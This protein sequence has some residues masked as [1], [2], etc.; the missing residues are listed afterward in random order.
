MK[1]LS[2]IGKGNNERGTPNVD[3]LIISVLGP[4]GCGKGT[5]CELLE[6]RYHCAHICAGD[7]LRSEVQKENSPWAA[8][9]QENI[10]A[11]KLGPK[12]MLVGII[13]QEIEILM[14]QGIQVFFVDGEWRNGTI[15]MSWD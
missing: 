5:Q 3:P 4:P 7:L 14:N 15:A 12:E 9:I 10:K 6:K 13:K 8:L 11:G 2:A 1:N